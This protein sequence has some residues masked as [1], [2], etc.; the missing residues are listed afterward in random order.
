MAYQCNNTVSPPKMSKTETY[1]L[2][3]DMEELMRKRGLLWTS[4]KFRFCIAGKHNITVS[5]TERS[6]GMRLATHYYFKQKTW[7]IVPLLGFENG[8]ASTCYATVDRQW[9]ICG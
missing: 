4:Q 8:G 5:F 7:K 2:I 6:D 9:Y 3:K 1:R